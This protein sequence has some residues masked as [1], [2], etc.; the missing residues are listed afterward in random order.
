MNKI[1]FKF[2][3]LSQPFSKVQQ[4]NSLNLYINIFMTYEHSRN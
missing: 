4:K 2:E 1:Q 3:Q